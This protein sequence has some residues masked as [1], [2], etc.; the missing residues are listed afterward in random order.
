M[1]LFDIFKRNPCKEC[2]RYHNENNTCQSKK[3]YTCGTN[4]YVGFLDRM[5]CKPYRGNQNE[6]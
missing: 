5:F 3:I 6:S 4:P 2:V 1:K